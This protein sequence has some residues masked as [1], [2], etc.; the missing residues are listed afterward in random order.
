VRLARTDARRRIAA[1]SEQHDKVCES[2]GDPVDPSDA[3]VEYAVPVKRYDTFGAPQYVEGL[4]VYFHT[5]HYPEG[6]DSY[7]R[8]PKPG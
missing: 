6:S 1:V 2:C 3:D 4:G 8:K 5:R 7:R